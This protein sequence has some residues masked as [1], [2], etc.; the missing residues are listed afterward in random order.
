MLIGLLFTPKVPTKSWI[1]Y[2]QPFP[3]NLRRI[4]VATLGQVAGPRSPSLEAQVAAFSSD[5]ILSPGLC[6]DPRGGGVGK[7]GKFAT[8]VRSCLHDK[9]KRFKRDFLGLEWLT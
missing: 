3:K 6:R 8:T 4:F 7:C 2:Q 9:V 1:Q 5:Q